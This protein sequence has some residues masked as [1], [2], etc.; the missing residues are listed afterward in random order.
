MAS[1]TYSYERYA[2]DASG[3]ADRRFVIPFEYIEQDHLSVRV[4]GTLLDPDDPALEWGLFNAS[5]VS[6]DSGYTMSDGD[7]VEIGR[8]SSP[9]TRL[10]DWTGAG[11]ITES[12]LDTAGEQFLYLIQEALDVFNFNDATLSY[13]P[14]LGTDGGTATLA[15][16][17]TRPIDT[18]SAGSSGITLASNQVTLPPG[19]YEVTAKVS[20]GAGTGLHKLRLQDVTNTDTLL[21]SISFNDGEAGVLRGTFDVEDDLAVELQ[22]NV[23]TTVADTGLGDAASLGTTEKFLDVRVKQHRKWR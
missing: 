18:L 22:H 15:T 12:D 5:T 20:V 6:I 4:N 13:A 16:W 7:T 8:A 17:N 11:I 3:N 10:V 2:W 14:A 21:E 1:S 9:G 19:R 23:T